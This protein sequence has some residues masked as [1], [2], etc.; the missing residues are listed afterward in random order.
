ML[1]CVRFLYSLRY[2]VK[3]SSMKYMLAVISLLVGVSLSA[4]S[5]EGYVD[6]GS[7]EAVIGIL[8]DY[9]DRYIHQPIGPES[10]LIRAWHPNRGLMPNRLPGT[11][12][13][14]WMESE[15]RPS[16]RV[17]PPIFT[18]YNSVTLRLGSSGAATITISNGSAYNHMPWPNSPAGY[19]DART[20][21]FPVPR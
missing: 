20:L 15:M 16:L 21:S 12:H 17:S 14:L 18:D 7:D 4:Q 9:N 10:W 6:V 5:P 8:A 11:N 1:M 13:T 3:S 2:I 19:R